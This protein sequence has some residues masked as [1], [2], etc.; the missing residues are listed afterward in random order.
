MASDDKAV[1]RRARV[2]EWHLSGYIL[3]RWR[4]RYWIETD[5]KF[6]GVTLEEAKAAVAKAELEVRSDENATIM[7]P[8]DVA[9][10][11]VDLIPAANSISV[12]DDGGTGV[13]VHRDWP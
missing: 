10:V 6:G 8:R 7:P 9:K 3:Q 4:V 13:V 11:L 12:C 5:P 1:V 2:Y